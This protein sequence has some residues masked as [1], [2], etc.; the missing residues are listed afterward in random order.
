MP[1]I[2][3]WNISPLQRPQTPVED[4]SA[5]LGQGSLDD[6]PPLE[7]DNNRN[8]TMD[9]PKAN[10]MPDDWCDQ[11][12]SVLEKVTAEFWGIPLDHVSCSF[13]QDPS[14]PTNPYPIATLIIELLFEKPERTHEKRRDYAKAL[15][16]ACKQELNRLRGTTDA[17][18]E[19]AVKRFN[20]EKDGFYVTSD[21]D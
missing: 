14:V 17:K 21:K 10:T 15:A 12:A 2:V 11:L 18:V 5:L 20:P 3:C 1:L 13:P 16:E 8:E 7:S 19:V 4:T 9:K 6:E